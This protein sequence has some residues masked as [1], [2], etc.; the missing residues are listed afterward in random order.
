VEQLPPWSLTLL[1]AELFFVLVRSKDITTLV[2]RPLQR[3]VHEQ[4]RFARGLLRSVVLEMA[5]FVPASAALL[6]L[7]SP[8]FV[9][10]SVIAPH[11]HAAFTLLGIASYGF[12]FA[13]V[14]RF[15]TRAALNTLKE[16]A[17]L[18]P[19]PTSDDDNV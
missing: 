7:I 11:P 8:L 3:S 12:P 9:W 18:S 13:T 16:F 1:A 14:K 19:T 5:V 2:K 10:P 15:I 6:L 4:H 17:A